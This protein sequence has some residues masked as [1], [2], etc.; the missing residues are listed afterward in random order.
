LGTC[1][2]Y[3]ESYCE[4]RYIRKWKQPSLFSVSRQIRSEAM[5][6]YYSSNEVILSC[7]NKEFNT[8]LQHYATILSACGNST[9]I[10]VGICFRLKTWHDMLAMFL[11]A[12]FIYNTD[13]GFVDQ[14]Q[15]AQHWASTFGAGGGRR[16]L[17]VAFR[18]AMLIAV[19][20]RHRGQSYAQ[21]AEDLRDWAWASLAW[22][23]STDGVKFF[24]NRTDGGQYELHKKLK[25]SLDNAD[26]IPQ[27]IDRPRTPTPEPEAR[28]KGARKK[29]CAASASD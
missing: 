16:L 11:P 3:T 9:D 25:S 6:I 4:R 29:K 19:K 15:E 2:A 17:S 10:S 18:D 5:S 7:S 8:D 24:R 12:K 26:T 22:L 20:A 27:V 28:P 14:T 21:L 13:L 1:R 23:G